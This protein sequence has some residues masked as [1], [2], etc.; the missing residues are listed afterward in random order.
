MATDR[1]GFLG[2]IGRG[3]GPRPFAADPAHDVQLLQTAASIENVLV[4]T[5]DTI[6]GLPAF[7]GPTSNAAI[8][9]F[10][11]LARAQHAEHA[12]GCND[13]AVALGGKAQ[14]GPNPF[15]A[16]AVTRAR[17]GLNDLA[18]ALELALQLETISAH[19]Y[20]FDV[21]TVTDLNARRLAASIMGVE[22]QHVGFLRVARGLL[23]ARTPELFVLESGNVTRLPAESGQAGSP[24][25]FARPDQA[26]PATEGAL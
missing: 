11:A 3:P 1:R 12:T 2:L 14:T 4:S 7:T 25:A 13:L 9:A 6:L 10:L 26:R 5:Y 22:A 15:A 19:N 20:Q 18:Q 24:E 21:G 23:A 17:P 8:R 16:Q